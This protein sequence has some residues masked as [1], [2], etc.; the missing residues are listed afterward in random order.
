MAATTCS[1]LSHIFQGTILHSTDDNPMMIL[2]NKVLGISSDGQI[3]FLEDS[4]ELERLKKTHDFSSERLIVLE[5][6]QF[7]IP[8]FIDTHIH[9]PQYPYMG[10]GYD[11]PLMGWL[12]KYTFPYE[13][14]YKDTKFAEDVYRKVVKRTLD[15]GTTTASYFATIHYEATTVLADVVE[16]FGQRGYVGKVCMDRNSPDFYV[17]QTEQSV[18]DT[19]RFIKYVQNKN[20]QL[21]TPV[22]TPRF[23]V[24]CSDELM[25]K[26]G[27]LARKYQ[28]P[29]Q[30]HL[31]E[32]IGEISLVKDMHPDCL[33]YTDVYRKHG[34]LTERSYMAHC[35]HICPKEARMLHECHTG[36]AHCPTSNL[37]IRSGFTDVKFIQN[38]N[39]KLGLGTDVA[40]GHSC[41]MLD[42]IRGAINV[43]NLLS[44]HKH[45]YQAISHKE[46]FAMATLGG[47]K[48]L[49]L[50]KKVGNFEVGKE[51]DA[52]LIDAASKDSP[53]DCFDEDLEDVVQKF[54]YCGDDRNIRKVYVK[55]KLVAGKDL[56]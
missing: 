38:N 14:K 17:E 35:C 13:S 54:F 48:V 34:L 9:A 24:S 47:S 30:S 50:D 2:R 12:E 23:V 42:T 36:V 28:L 52:L 51:F 18:I 29:V 44:I 22:I 15:L 11:L 49:G 31:S 3:V 5:D 33:H 56:L 32:N 27:D 7:I 26:L 39:V 40:G 37:N 8:G 41:S 43:S 4:S 53:F 16:E 45:D 6:R 25:H 21:I 19:E 10:T 46:A 55:G 1:F 20:N